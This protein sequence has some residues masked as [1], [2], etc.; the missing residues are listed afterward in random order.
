MLARTFC[1]RAPAGWDRRPSFTHLHAS[2]S[3]VAAGLAA[4]RG[5][6]R[7]FTAIVP[8]S[9]G[10]EV[11]VPGAALVTCGGWQGLSVAR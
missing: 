2:N 6:E 9:I 7:P 1:K 3:S 4:S 5:L 8:Q 11:L 10:T